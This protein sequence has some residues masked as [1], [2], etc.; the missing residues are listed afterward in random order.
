MTIFSMET[1]KNI[2][3]NIF[4]SKMQKFPLS[5]GLVIWR[6]LFLVGPKMIEANIEQKI[7]I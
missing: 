6:I 4:A 1:C 5:I 2:F 7:M 3:Y